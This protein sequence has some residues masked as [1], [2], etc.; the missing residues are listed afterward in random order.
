MDAQKGEL[1]HTLIVKVHGSVTN[2]P[3]LGSRDDNPPE[4]CVITEDNYIDFLSLSPING[5][6]P[7]AILNKLELSK[8]LFLGYSIRDWSSR[9]LL[10]RMWRG[11]D[12]KRAWAVQREHGSLV[13]Y[14]LWKRGFNVDLHSSLLDEY[15]RELREE[16]GAVSN[17]R[18]QP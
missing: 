2:W 18:G 13:E 12:H 7:Y 5:L 11:K 15:V 17:D 4:E 16:I 1:D 14:E 9:V 10:R 8:F 3:V 6:V